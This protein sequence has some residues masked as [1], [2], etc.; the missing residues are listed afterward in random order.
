MQHSKRL[1]DC[2]LVYMC[3]Q[4]VHLCSVFCLLKSLLIDVT[5]T[6]W[7]KWLCSPKKLWYVFP[8]IIDFPNFVNSH[9]IAGDCS[10]RVFDRLCI[11][12]IRM[13]YL[14][15][16]TSS[17]WLAY[18]W[19]DISI[20][21]SSRNVTLWNYLV[22][23]LSSIPSSLMV[24]YVEPLPACAALFTSFSIKYSHCSNPGGQDMMCA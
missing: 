14:W 16:I 3:V 19:V 24:W 9:S 12:C 18:H 8:I 20:Y 17:P 5:K 23:T 4:C 22:A 1:H 2:K 13:C 6:C 11:C 21:F 7:R 10:I 15:K